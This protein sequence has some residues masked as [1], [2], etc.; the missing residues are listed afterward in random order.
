MAHLDHG[1]SKEEPS[2]GNK[3]MVT[4]GHV[5]LEVERSVKDGEVDAT[6]GKSG[7]DTE[8]NATRGTGNGGWRSNKSSQSLFEH[9]AGRGYLSVTDIVSLAWCEVQS[10][11]GVL[12]GRNLP[13]DQRPTSFTTK[14]GTIISPDYDLAAEREKTLAKGRAIHAELEKE[15]YA[16]QIVIP[17]ETTADKWALRILEVCC[18]LKNL[19]ND[20]ICR[21][22]RVFAIIDGFLVFG[23]IDEIEVKRKHV[24]EGSQDSNDMVILKA[25]T[26]LGSSGKQEARG[27]LQA[28]NINTLHMHA[29]RS[30]YSS[31]HS[32]S[33]TDKEVWSRQTVKHDVGQAV[34]TAIKC[35]VSFVV[36]DSKTRFSPTIPRIESQASARLQCM[37]YRR[38]LEELC[39]GAEQY[40]ASA[41]IG[42]SQQPTTQLPRVSQFVPCDIGTFLAKKNIDVHATLSN[43]FIT[44]SVEWCN[45]IGLSTST[46]SL[47]CSTSRLN[48]I[49]A[50]IR[51][52]ADVVGEARR[53]VTTANLMSD[54]LG[55][56]FRHRAAFKRK[57]TELLSD[58]DTAVA[59]SKPVQQQSS[60]S[61]ASPSAM[62]LH[63]RERDHTPQHG[64][65][66]LSIGVMGEHGTTS[67]VQKTR[68]NQHA[69]ELA[70]VTI[71][72]TQDPSVQTS[73]AKSSLLQQQ[74]IAKVA[75]SYSA[76]ELDAH[77]AKV[78][79]VWLGRRDPNGVKE[80]ETYKCS[81]CE[82]RSDCEWR[83]VKAQE[84]LERARARRAAVE[85]E[86]LWVDQD[87][88]LFDGI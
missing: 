33:S 67:A 68:A 34:N 1:R 56:T 51:T 22:V 83:A 85:E 69:N 17:T 27:Q 46:G 82:F 25:S 2:R 41:Q 18:G 50:L 32:V 80:A 57:T 55:L 44:A 31:S 60:S 63:G 8:L 70:Q 36:S 79:P 88:N 20:G 14:T 30:S 59:E 87:E 65:L 52:L 6:K 61:N 21:E 10:L 84:S 62:R 71:Q 54:E 64:I 5:A 78:M 75:F 86:K 38:M 16:E 15:L 39:L 37:L 28:D 72:T 9:A 40:A 42:L 76:S 58:R 11:Y 12:G 23:Q 4:A 66:P 26:S 73:H 53:M 29:V 24:G 7:T 35:E 45:R 13:L 81:S 74:V 48:S 47:E 49:H 43:A 77:L 3:Y 19:L